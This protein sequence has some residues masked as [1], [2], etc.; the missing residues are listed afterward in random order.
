MGPTLE[1]CF[2]LTRNSPGKV[3]STSEAPHSHRVQTW[4]VESQPKACSMF[5]ER[6]RAT[7][8]VS[9]T[10]L[11]KLGHVLKYQESNVPGR[12]AAWFPHQPGLS[13]AV[14]VCPMEELAG[15]RC[16]GVQGRMCRAPSSLGAAHD[17]ITRQHE[18]STGPL[19]AH[20]P[21]AAP[22]TLW[23]LSNLFGW[24]TP[25]RGPFLLHPL[26]THQR[27]HRQPHEQ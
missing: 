19:P 27:P 20:Q 10:H 8:L 11:G 2:R 14:Q 17:I 21:F 12:Q 4:G 6:L 15:S 3:H 26:Q 23:L 13:W 18:R 16:P 24:S 1:S 5:S 7:Q 25:T 22:A 9:G